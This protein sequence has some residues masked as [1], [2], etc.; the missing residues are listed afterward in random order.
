MNCPR[1]TI[2][3]LALAS[4]F[5]LSG[6]PTQSQSLPTALTPYFSNGDSV[7]WR[8]VHQR[9]FPGEVCETS[10]ESTYSLQIDSVNGDTAFGIL[11]VA[12][13]IEPFVTLSM[14]GVYKT[15]GLD[16]SGAKH[17][18]GV[19]YRVRL[20]R[21]TSELISADADRVSE[22]WHFVDSVRGSR[23]AD[24]VNLRHQQMDLRGVWKQLCARPAEGLIPD[25]TDRGLEFVYTSGEQRGGTDN[26]RLILP[27]D[28]PLPLL[29]SFE[30]DQYGRL[31]SR[32][33]VIERSGRSLT[34]PG[35]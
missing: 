3:F 30:S 4:T 20:N 24:S 32:R 33:C 17:R 23:T 6:A 25:S 5:L 8:Y 22:K 18:Y 16:T 19:Q 15:R 7:V 31:N 9:Y 34:L 26:L 14:D 1:L 35:K 28:S 27:D 13:D 11:D 12:G 2:I 21:Y 29:Y 10:F